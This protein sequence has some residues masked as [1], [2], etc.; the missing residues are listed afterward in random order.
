MCEIQAFLGLTGYYRRFVPGYAK[1]AG[2]MIDLLS[3]DVSFR[4]GLEQE[5]SFTE[6][7]SALSRVPIVAYLNAAN[8][9]ILDTAA[10][11]HAVGTMLSQ[12][13]DGVE[14]VI[15]YAS[16]RLD[17]AQQRYCV[18][19]RELLAVVRFTRHCRHYLLGCHFVLRSDH[20]SLAWLFRF[21]APKG[22]PARWLEELS[23]Y[24][25]AIE[26]RAGRKHCNADGMSRK[27]N[28]TATMQGNG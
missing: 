6:L 23:Q 22:E 26:H 27:E 20:G 15:A 21:K 12:R 10:S 1:I 3:K 16:K 13:Q 17:L 2:P 11:F 4:W 28:V 14:Q 18:T 25:F 19:R 7:K 9:F 24:D 8:T 5:Y